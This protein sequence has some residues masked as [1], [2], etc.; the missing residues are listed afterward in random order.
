MLVVTEA[1]ANELRAKLVE[2]TA[3]LE[4]ERRLVAELTEEGQ[5]LAAERDA[6]RKR[7]AELEQRAADDVPCGWTEPPP[8]YPCKR[9]TAK[10]VPDQGV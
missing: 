5:G 4:S 3:A 8:G 1:E 10:S 9:V 2:L 6:L 7:V